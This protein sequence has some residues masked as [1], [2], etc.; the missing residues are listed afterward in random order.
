MSTD[1][2]N[3]DGEL[4]VNEPLAKYTSWRVGG[5]A[6]QLYRAT[7]KLDLASF[8]SQ[9]PRTEQVLWLGLGS[10]LLVRDGGFAGTVISTA[11]I[12]KNIDVKDESIEAEVG[13]Y[14]SKLAK[15]AARFGLSGAG[16]LA[17]IPG[18]LGGALAMNAG[19]HGT[20]IWSLIDGVTTINRE[21]QLHHRVPEEFKV[22][23]RHVVMP[24]GEWFLSA[25]LNL[26]QGE[27]AHE[28]DEIKALLKKRNISQP[29]NLPSAGSVFR[30][31]ENDFAGRLIE[32]SGLKGFIIGGA[33][34][35]EKHANFI[36]NTGDAT[37]ADIE[38]LIIYVQKKIELEHG[39]LLE[40]EIRIV[41]EAV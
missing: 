13:V 12:L 28:M 11:G 34:V 24:T 31:P 17:G 35:S 18:T 30:N 29:T 9:L 3:I 25:T 16:F 6:D 22:G 5:S 2:L 14:C 4:R 23:Y 36:V 41:G 15:Q 19:A 26:K 38:A 27:K 39:V 21:G 1:F 7:N 8:L 37:A 10:N 32:A 40:P 33:A 20:E